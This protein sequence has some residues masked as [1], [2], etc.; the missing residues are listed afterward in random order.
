MKEP[1]YATVKM[2]TGEEVLAL[3]TVAEE[4]GVE[5][6]I[7][8]NPITVDQNNTIDMEKGVAVSNLVPRKWLMYSGE[9][10]VIVH[11]DKII[12]VSELDQF[13]VE[14]YQNALGVAKISSPIKRKINTT[15]HHGYLGSIDD[16]RDVLERI[17]NN[18]QETKDQ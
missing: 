12:T 5:F 1:F 18:T 7:L 10:M 2:V 6:L 17:F 8:H 13:G 16:A 9:D 11:K 15:K 4:N 14:F 3:T